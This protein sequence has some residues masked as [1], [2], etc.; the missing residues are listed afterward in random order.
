MSKQFS[1]HGVLGGSRTACCPEALG[2]LFSDR[3]V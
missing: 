1:G 3:G 2:G